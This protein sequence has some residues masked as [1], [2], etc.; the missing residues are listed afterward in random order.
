VLLV[1]RISAPTCY[2]PFVFATPRRVALCTAEDNKEFSGEIERV[3]WQLCDTIPS[4]TIA[5]FVDGTLYVSAVLPTTSAFEAAS[6]TP[7]SSMAEWYTS[8]S[9]IIYSRLHVVEQ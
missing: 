1:T 5:N 2:L 4:N 6:I 8:F 3:G 9:L 7:F